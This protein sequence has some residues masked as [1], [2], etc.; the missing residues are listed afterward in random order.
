[1]A[2]GQF[3]SC[4]YTSQIT[5]T[6]GTAYSNLVTASGHDENGRLVSGSD[7]PRVEIIAR[8]IDLVIVKDAS[9]PTPLNGVVT[10]RLRVTNKGP[11]T[12][13]NVQLADPAPAG[14]TYLT[15]NPSQGTCDLSPSL[16]TCGP[17]SIAAGQTVTMST[18]A[19]GTAVG[20]HTNTATVTGG[21]GR[22]TNPADNVD[23]ATTVVPQ[24][25]L[26]PEPSRPEA[27]LKLTVA[28]KVMKADGKID[29]VVVK[30]TAGGKRVAG[31]R[32]LVTGVGVRKTARSNRKGIAV[33]FVNPQK[34]GL[35]TVST[36]KSKRPS[37][38][39]KRIGVVAVFLPP[40]QVSAAIVP[41][42]D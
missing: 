3:A 35:L 31:V 1:M 32:V 10:Y 20:S 29:R 23:S 2:P 15:A 5:G 7:E 41:G 28:P 21:G 6:G 25:L 39:T 12:A 22:E 40:L 11:D 13:T 27:C 37:C 36:F 14:I 19:R 42:T 9:S 38:G 24:P 16:I 30:V 4:Q 8:L 18:T 26:A 17:G 34:A 33:L